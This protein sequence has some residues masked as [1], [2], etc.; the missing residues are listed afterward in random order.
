MV[1]ALP[2]SHVM[3]VYTQPEVE[4][5]SVVHALP[6]LHVM[7]CGLHWPVAGTQ[8]LV[9]HESGEHT[10]EGVYMQMPALHESVVQR[11]LSLQV[12][13]CGLHA[14]VAALHELG[15]HAVEGHKVVLT[16]CK[17]QYAALPAPPL[18][19]AVSQADEEYPAA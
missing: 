12:M 2:S 19:T 15:M 11:L 18:L 13:G 5:L 9:W 8:A 3:G 10:T 1:Q 6:S 16:F 14:P 17:K 7:G 4:Q